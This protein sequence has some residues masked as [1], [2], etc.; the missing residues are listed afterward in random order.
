MN[1]VNFYELE[2]KINICNFSL[3][4]IWSTFRDIFIVGPMG[5][6]HEKQVRRVMEEIHNSIF[7]AWK[8]NMVPISR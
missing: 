4:L 1:L 5:P 7:G 8:F 3:V 2:K 6:Y